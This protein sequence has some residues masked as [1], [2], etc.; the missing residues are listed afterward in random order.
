MR[1]GPQ[2]VV[3]FKGKGEEEEVDIIDNGNMI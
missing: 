3:Q 2:A 1:E